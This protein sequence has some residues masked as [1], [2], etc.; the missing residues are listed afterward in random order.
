MGSFPLRSGDAIPASGAAAPA[1]GDAIPVSGDA[2]P[3]SGAAVSTFD[4]AADT[5]AAIS[6]PPAPAGLGVIRLSGPEA[7]AVA[8]RVF[9]PARGGTLAAAGGYTAHYGH[10]FDAEG[11]IDECVAT[12]FLAPHSYTGENVVEL[13]CHGGVYLLRRALRAA[14]DAGARPAEAGE[15]TRRAFLNGK[16][17]LT[18]AEAVM[19]LISANG[20]LAAKTAL[21]A[22]EG[23]V[24]RRLSEVKESLL[25][26]LAQ[27]A[28]FVDYPDED[29]PELRPE[30]LAATLSGAAGTLADLLSTFDAG[31]V[32]QEG[33]DTA[34]VG[35]PNVG[36]STLMNAFT[37]CDSSIVT[38]IPGTTRDVVEET[39]RLG[40]VVLRLA[41]TAGIRDTADPVEAIGVQR[42]RRRMEQAALV[43]AMFDGSRPLS[44]E[45]RAFAAEV[46][47]DTAIAVINKADKPLLIDKEYIEGVFQHTVIL[48]AATGQGLEDLTEEIA[49]IT[50]V[51]A[52]TGDEPILTGER[53]RRCARRSLDALRE[54]EAALAGGWTLDAVTVSVDDALSAILELTG[55]RA[56]EA[57]VDEVFARFCVGK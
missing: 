34:I 1:S 53:Q 41:D 42:A 56:T 28:A 57:V 14:L 51:A 17:D 29:I 2:I 11:D 21:A 25:G 9:R 22:R 38:E 16:L 46:A 7:A 49:Q 55:E 32:L 18:G 37:G 6:T 33:V 31:K 20:R 10:V 23:A 27:L 8:D 4:T 26:A 12:V 35:S 54:A 50:G 24:F 39:V 52:L 45:D 3:A 40:D 47:S 13:S 36:K 19:S 43:L 48:S 44:D 15:F 30:A 5:I